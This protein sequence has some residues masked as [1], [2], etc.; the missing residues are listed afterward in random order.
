MT[1]SENLRI[2]SRFIRFGF[3]TFWIVS[4]VYIN[5]FRKAPLEKGQ[6][7][8]Q[9]WALGTISGIYNFR[10]D[11]KGKVP[12]GQHLFV[13][14]HRAS[15]DPI[16]YLQYIKAFPVSRADVEH[17]PLVGRGAKTVGTLFVNKTN[18]VSRAETIKAI[19]REFRNG[20]S[21]MLFPEGRTHAEDLTIRL[22]VGSFRA[23]AATNTPVFP[24]AI[25]YQNQNDYWTHEDPFL[26]H[27][28]A[29]FGRRKETFLKVRYGESIPPGDP[30]EMMQT[31]RDW[32]DKQILEMREE[33]GGTQIMREIK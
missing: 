10:V 13:S 33:W 4:R 30:E 31:A 28:N 21:I 16:V 9:Q 24:M 8:R 22:H 14:N 2:W 12:E 19:E 6:R 20:N 23:A 32:I 7:I 5:S 25:D 15:I 18:R 26:T 27:Y 3:F 11:I 17:Y 29:Q 1:F